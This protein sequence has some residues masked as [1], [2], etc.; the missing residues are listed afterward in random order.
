MH[1]ALIFDSASIGEWVVLLAVLLIVMG[2]KRLPGLMRKFG[3]YYAKF[4]R[5]AENFKRQVIEMEDEVMREDAPKS[6]PFPQSDTPPP[7]PS[8]GQE[9]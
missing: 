2:P 8:P 4:K 7:P 1:L 6:D 3:N 5:T 9:G